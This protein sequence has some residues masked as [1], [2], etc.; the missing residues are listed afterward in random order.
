M[1]SLAD[2]LTSG[3]LARVQSCGDPECG[4]LFVDASRAGSR[5]WCA[6]DGCGNRNKARRHYAR[7][8]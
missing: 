5:R 2:L 3:D 6:M 7:V 8:K 1:R 4:W